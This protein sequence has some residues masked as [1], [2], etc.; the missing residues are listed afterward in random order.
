MWWL[1]TLIIL[2]S[3]GSLFWWL[4]RRR[5]Q[6]KARL[7]SIVGLV[8]EP[9]TFDPPVVAAMVQRAWKCDVGD[10][11]ESGPDGF[12]VGGETPMTLVRCQDEMFMLN[13]FP[14]PYI[15]NPEQAA[16]QIGDLRL[17]T[18]FGEHRAWFSVDAFGIEPET[19]E[20]KVQAAYRRLGSLFAEF[21]DERCQ[22]IF[23]PD[24]NQLFPV[25]EETE[26]ALRSDDPYTALVRTLPAPLVSVNHD[27]PLMRE[28]EQTARERFP[29]FVA[30]WETQAGKDFMLKAPVERGGTTEF[31]WIN[32]TA[33]EGDRLYG[34]L[35]NE[36]FQLAGLSL[37]SKVSVAV[38]DL[39]D[40]GYIDPKDNFVGGFTI[41]A[42]QK[43]L[44]RKPEPE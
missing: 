7:V 34:T 35:A 42:M 23:L 4:R 41:T 20:E 26:A 5:A 15:E 38:G 39:N 9:F 8:T 22:L 18:L 33:M 31:I 25:N 10:G 28:A 43:A 40:W 17:A 24:C 3:I 27:D 13:A 36:P 6:P 21:I 12:V 11:T 37:G 1:P 16:E 44:Q 30:A 2:V 29:E 19:P 14:S 32:V